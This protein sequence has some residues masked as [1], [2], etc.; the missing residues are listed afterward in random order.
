[1]KTTS[2]LFSKSDKRLL[3]RMR[4]AQIIKVGELTRLKDLSMSPIYVD[5]RDKLTEAHPELL[6]LV[7]RAFAQTIQ[8]IAETEKDPKP[9]VVI[10]VPDAAHPLAAATA[11]MAALDRVP[12]SCLVQRKAPKDHGTSEQ[13]GKLIIGKPKS[14]LSY[15]LIDDVITT[16][17]SKRE[18]IAVMEAEGFEVKRVLVFFDRQQGGGDSL[19][20]D[21]YKFYA[22]FKLL[23]V[24]AFF[25]DEGLITSEQYDEV[26]N[27]IG[28]HQVE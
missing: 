1:M 19:I 5:M 26:I 24:G 14:N 11:T 2:Y 22:V 21:G 3:K 4:L 8:M 23:E 15:N 16:S 27:F 12:I 28:T 13:K 6:P 25:L 10:G 18:S 17:A 7:G 9:Q 20:R